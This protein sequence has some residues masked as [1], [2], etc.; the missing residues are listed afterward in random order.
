MAELT[1]QKLS[2]N[3]IAPNLAAPAAGGDS[4][5]WSPGAFVHVKNADTVA[6]TVTVA[7]AYGS[8]APLGLQPKDLS[9]SV[10]AGAERKIGPFD[11]KAFANADNLI[12]LSYDAVT[13]LTLG[14]FSV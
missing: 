1:V 8:D 5:P 10:P 14:A 9:I 7:S 12:N 4:F 13:G 11:R 3:G 2:H 6:H